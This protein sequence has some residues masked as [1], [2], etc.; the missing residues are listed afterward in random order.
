MALIK[1]LPKS[2]RVKLLPA[3]EKADIIADEIENRGHPLFYELSR[4]VKMRFNADIPPSVWSDE[5]LEPHLKMRISIR[6][7]EDNEIASSRDL[8]ILEEIS[9]ANNLDS[10]DIF[11]KAKKVGDRG[12]NLMGFFNQTQFKI[13][14]YFNKVR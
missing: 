6:D 12:Y 10:A 7:E 11:E 4:F 9:S 13:S 5:G 1:N 14:A 8:Q 2:Y 3:S